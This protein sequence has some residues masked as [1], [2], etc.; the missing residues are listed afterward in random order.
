[1]IKALYKHLLPEK[2]RVT[3]RQ[4]L[5]KMASPLYAGKRF[6]CNCCGKGFRKFLPKGNVKRLNAVCPYCG[7]L[8]RTRLLHLYLQNETSLFSESIKVLH[9][10]P[11]PCLYDTLSKLSITYID[12][13]I[14]PALAKHVVDITDIPYPDHH[15]DLI[16]CSHVLGHVPDEAKA[17][18][19]LRRVLAPQGTALILT[20]LNPGMAHTYEDAGIT[21]PE[22]RLKHF[23]EADL[24]R[25]HGQDFG[26]RLQSQGFT[27]ERIDYRQHL[28]QEL[29]IRNS[30]GNGEREIIFRC[31]KV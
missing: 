25:L 15:F 17:I 3:L 9:F 7:S 14:N 19:E 23:G 13:D 4:N 31:N 1:M 24:C 2:Q 10:A 8:E 6:Y 11:E 20:L 28:P 29:V 12:A 26:S 5:R 16:I 21:T 27:V 18:Q 22:Q 30:L